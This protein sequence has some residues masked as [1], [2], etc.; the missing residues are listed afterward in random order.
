MAEQGALFLRLQLD[1]HDHFVDL[2]RGIHGNTGGVGIAGEG[3]HEL[4]P[5]QHEAGTGRAVIEPQIPVRVGLHLFGH[6][7]EGGH[8]KLCLLYTSPFH[9]GGC[10]YAS[11]GSLVKGSWHGRSP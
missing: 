2:L 11:S 10:C 8:I 4:V 3:H 5:L 7:L 9:K 6:V 1:F